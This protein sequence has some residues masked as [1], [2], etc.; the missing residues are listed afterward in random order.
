M[1][2]TWSH[3]HLADPPRPLTPTPARLPD[4][5][6]YRITICL[7]CGSLMHTPGTHGSTCTDCAEA[8]KRQIKHQEVA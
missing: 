3:M 1:S 8:M 6:S 5:D 2:R 4:P 7:H